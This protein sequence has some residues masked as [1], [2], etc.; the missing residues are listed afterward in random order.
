MNIE[1]NTLFR[2]GVAL[3]TNWISDFF[4]CASLGI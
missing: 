4:C 3:V 2:S 1:Y